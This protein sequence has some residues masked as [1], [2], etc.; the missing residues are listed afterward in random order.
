VRGLLQRQCGCGQH[1]I[2]GGSCSRCRESKAPPIVHDVLR[3][4]GRPLE[5]ASRSLMESHF[6]RDF[7]HV[8]VHAGEHA[9]VSARAVDAAAY[10]V[11]HDIVFA[12]GQ[13]APQSQSG[14]RLLAHELTH[15][16]Q[17]MSV[18][19]PLTVGSPDTAAENEAETAARS[20]D[21]RPQVRTISSA[22]ARLQRQPAGKKDAT[23]EAGKGAAP[24]GDKPADFG[25]ALVVVDHGATSV[26]DAARDRLNEIYMN[27]RSAN[28]AELK[29]EGITSI[30]LHII[31]ENKKLT[32]L[33][34]FSSLRGQQTPDGRHW[35]NVR[36][37]GGQHVGN[38]IRYAVAEEE[39]KGTHGHGAA[40][41]LGIVGGLVGGLAG[42]AAG[43]GLGSIGGGAGAAGREKG[44]A[45]AGGIAGAAAGVAA[46]VALGSDIDKSTGY[47]EEFV[48][49]HETG[50]TVEQFA[51]TP[52][53]QTK[54]AQLYAARKRAGGP[55][56]E[57]AD[58]TSS[59]KDEYFA[60][61]TAAYFGRP[62]NESNRDTYNREWLHKNDPE[63]YS[64]LN[65]IFKSEDKAKTGAMNQQPANRQPRKVAA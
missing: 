27:L 54:L 23:K 43:F 52:A 11:G 1:T 8:R 20:L 35:E 21:E 49:S 36:G 48:A 33:P 51:L 60:Q 62:Y 10:T 65:E 38:K 50:H 34:E 55:W 7:S 12:A 58:Y 41:A 47:G 22:R 25:I 57:P 45:I 18:E 56:L 24:Q 31:P 64:F 9:A 28:L 40:I 19:G 4:P 5:P 42:A 26:A 61:C 32:D 63:M 6:G 17:K 29:R 30:E 39:I 13:Y 59:N 37:A 14:Q 2:G 16:L 44:G 15:T 46:G 53:Q 3:S